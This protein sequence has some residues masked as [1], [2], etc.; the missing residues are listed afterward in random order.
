MN[1]KYNGS[2]VIYSKK[3]FDFVICCL[4]TLYYDLDLVLNQVVSNGLEV[5]LFEIVL[6]PQ[7][8]RACGGLVIRSLCCIKQVELCRVHLPPSCKAV[9]IV[10]S[11]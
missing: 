5:A 11:K 2:S 4:V 8:E 10:H 1:K 9:I 3:T 6:P 7:C